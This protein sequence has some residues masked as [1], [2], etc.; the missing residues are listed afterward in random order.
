MVK[1]CISEYEVP[2]RGFDVSRCPVVRASH[3]PLHRYNLSLW[4]IEATISNMNVIRRYKGTRPL[5]SKGNSCCT[6]SRAQDAR[7]RWYHA[8][9]RR[10]KKEKEEDRIKE[11][12]RERGTE[13]ENACT[14]RRTV[15]EKSYRRGRRAK[16]GCKRKTKRRRKGRND[17]T[18]GT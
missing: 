1:I 7:K 8:V 6:R 9:S 17:K 5:T 14:T 2:E 18:A 4:T 16:K 11:V 12:G 15:E 10:A 3:T 13:K